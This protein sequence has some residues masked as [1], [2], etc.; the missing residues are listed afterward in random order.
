MRES[1]GLRAGAA[2]AG[3]TRFASAQNINIGTYSGQIQAQEQE[4]RL[5][6]DNER[7]RAEMA[8]TAS[9]EKKRV[10]A[11]RVAAAED[12]LAM[13]E[14]KRDRWGT[15]YYD[16][17]KGRYEFTGRLGSLDHPGNGLIGDRNKA[18]FDSG[19]KSYQIANTDVINA[20][21]VLQ[22]ELEK[23]VAATARLGRVRISGPQGVD[24]LAAIGDRH[25]QSPRITHEFGGWQNRADGAW[26]L[27]A[28]RRCAA[29]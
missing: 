25:T 22:Q 2:A 11:G 18:E 7:A 8:L 4:R 19:V 1:F 21:K 20:N 24:R 6:A 9:Q 26:L 5:A 17:G 15:P 13:A 29:S 16:S 23:S 27:A 3:S 14:A 12:R 10:Q 28:L